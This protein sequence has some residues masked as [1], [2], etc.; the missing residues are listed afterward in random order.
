[1]MKAATLSRSQLSPCEAV[2]A[3]LPD[4]GIEFGY[5]GIKQVV[6]KSFTLS[7]PS[8]AQVRFQ[9]Q[10]QEQGLFSVNVSSG[11]CRRPRQCAL[12]AGEKDTHTE[13]RGAQVS[14]SRRF[15]NVIAL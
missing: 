15:E 11:K 10:Q 12:T 8:N 1:M 2:I 5:C 13:G 4:S 9:V 7:N 3:S 14:S 6:T